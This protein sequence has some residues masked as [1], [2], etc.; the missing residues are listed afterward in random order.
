MTNRTN[1]KTLLGKRGQRGSMAGVVLALLMAASV[2]FLGA[3]LTPVYLDHS[4]MVTVMQKM[5][6]ENDLA[7]LNDAKI[8]E[9]MG[10]RLKI[11]NIR[12]FDLK[13]NL[14]IS[15]GANRVELVLGYE[16]RIDLFAN[17][18]LVAVFENKV[19]LRD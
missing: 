6:Q 18:Y 16:I 8:R 12:K 4:T 14:K 9:T 7:L 10:V 1:S 5:S 3:R 13:E 17:L 19:P 11:N 15:R 2:I